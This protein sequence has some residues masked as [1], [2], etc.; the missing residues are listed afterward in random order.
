[1]VIATVLLSL[2]GVGAGLALGARD[3]GDVRTN[4]QTGGPQTPAAAPTTGRPDGPLC[5]PQTQE[6]AQ[7]H[8]VR[9]VL[10][11]VLMIR[12]KTSVAYICE[13]PD[14]HLYYHANNTR[15]GAPWVEG[16]SAIF[17]GDVIKDGDEYRA[18]A[19]DGV[20]FS[21]TKARLEIVHKDGTTE[22]QNASP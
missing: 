11:Q 5:L 1:V 7:A 9:G 10:T 16:K 4:P 12:T 14:G 13:D 21:V 17:L 19:D 20:V 2:I 15:G 22:T 6:T 3:R 18:T 8:G